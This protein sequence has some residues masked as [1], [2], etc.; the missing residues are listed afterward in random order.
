LR[1][2]AAQLGVLLSS[3]NLTP[4][5]MLEEFHR[6]DPTG[7]EDR[8]YAEIVKNAP[9]LKLAETNVVQTQSDL[10]QAELNLSYCTVYAEIDGVITRRDVNPGDNLQAGQSVMAPL[11]A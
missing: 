6:R 5:Q 4:K 8:I 9:T 10:D 1:Q 2:S 11:A 3:Y 7:N